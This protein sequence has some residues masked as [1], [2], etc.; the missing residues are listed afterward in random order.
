MSV[1]YLVRH[2]QAS[3]GADDYD[4]LSPA[5]AKQCE[6]LGEH[7]AAIGRDVEHVFAGRLRRHQQSAAAFLR[8]R[9]AAGLPARAV[10]LLP[11]LAEYDYM[12]LLGAYGRTQA[13][14]PDWQAMARNPKLFDRVLTAALER[15]VA[16][17]LEEPEPYTEFRD[18]CHGILLDVMGRIG[19]GT[20]GIV[21][22]SAGSLGAGM[23]P[24][25]GL[26]DLAAM[27]LKLQFHNSSVT[28]VLFDGVRTTVESV[29]VI[30]H[31]EKPGLAALV[32]QR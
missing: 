24:M 8:G 27:R 26:S 9:A 11:D 32:T 4:Q 21:F 30:A 13:D 3:F 10:Q 22:G 15:W 16:G 20:A 7:W 2:G 14:V 5:G 6:L 29:N 28:K 12:A 18:R 31:L 17:D 19:R 1:L 23:Q 25:L